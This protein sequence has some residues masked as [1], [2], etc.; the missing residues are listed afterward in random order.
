MPVDIYEY[1]TFREYL[2]AFLSE[3]GTT[4]AAFAKA[5]G[6][7]TALVSWIRNGKRDLDPTKISAWS[8]AM[9]HDEDEFLYFLALVEVDSRSARIRRIGAQAHIRAV[10][11]FRSAEQVNDERLDVFFNWHYA[12]I[13]ELAHCES[14][15]A[16]P[17]WIAA[18][19]TPRI[20][21]EQAAEALAGL[22]ANRLLN[23]VDGRLVPIDAIVTSPNIPPGKVSAASAVYLLSALDRASAALLETPA[24][25]RHFSSTMIS[26]PLSAIPFLKQRMQNLERE[27]IAYCVD[28][29]KR[30]RVFQLAFVLFPVSRPTHGDS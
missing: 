13:L 5:V 27:L 20:T 23:E 15:Q 19:L 11:R 26:L 21:P 24:A 4:A 7:S 30:E 8:R 17:E 3:P 2:D 9:G 22:L 29:T 6:C 14:F 12:A 1:T 10:R 28:Q 18:R 16:D 25:E